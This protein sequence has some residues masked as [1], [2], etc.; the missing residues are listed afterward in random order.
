MSGLYE[1]GVSIPREMYGAG[2]V[3]FERSDVAWRRLAGRV[4]GGGFGA[5]GTRRVPATFGRGCGTWESKVR[6]PKSEVQS[7][8]FKV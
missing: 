5:D 7:P 1:G 3:Q 4:A 2:L 8:R 6:S